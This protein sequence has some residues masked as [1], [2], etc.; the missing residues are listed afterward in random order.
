MKR[1]AVITLLILLIAGTLFL[2]LLPKHTQPVPVPEPVAVTNVR[3]RAVGQKTDVA[4][5]G[6]PE[7]PP[8][9]AV[10]T[11]C[12]LDPASAGRYE[13]RNNALRS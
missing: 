1:I 4:P 12:G 5:S 8:H 13:T 10:A 3:V 9:G 2:V 6:I 11:V 7:S